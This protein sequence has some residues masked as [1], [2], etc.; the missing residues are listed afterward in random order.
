MD[1]NSRDPDDLH[2]DT[3]VCVLELKV[4][5]NGSMS[6][7]GSITDEVYTL[8]LLD[9]ARDIIKSYHARRRSGFVSSLV[10]PAHDTALVGTPEEKRLIA[11]RDELSNAMAR[12]H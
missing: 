10:V 11:A 2:G 6:V 12:A 4:R 1:I 3:V 8:A 7:G 9:T 5:R